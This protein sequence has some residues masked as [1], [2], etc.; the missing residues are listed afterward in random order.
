MEIQ[1][2]R[3]GEG[4]LHRLNVLDIAKGLCMISV[5]FAHVNLTPMFLIPIYSF[6][7]PL[8]FILAG[9]VYDPRKYPRL[10]DQIQRRWHTLIKP[11]LF[12]SVTAVV[13]VFVAEKL[14]VHAEDLKLREYVSA[15]IQIVIAQGSKPVLNTPL[16]FVPCLFAIEIMYFFLAKLKT[17]SCAMVCFALACVGWLLQSGMLPFDNS[18]LPWTFDSALFALSFYA[19]G[20]RMFP[21]IRR[22]I[23]QI[24]QHPKRSRICLE[25]LFVC[26][27]I[28]LPLAKINGK[29]SLGS[30]ILNNGFLFFLTGMLGTFAV[31]L[32]S[33]MLENN[34]FL[35]WMGKNTFCLMSVHYMLRRYTLPKYYRMLGIPLYKRK[36]FKETIIPFLIIFLVSILL[37]VMYNISKKMLAQYKEK[38]R[39]S[40]QKI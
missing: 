8:F 7:M 37:T 39:R 3:H 28:W 19:A 25:M 6:H 2:E 34:R 29:V 13:Y 26:M 9:M 20:N 36:V 27:L 10:R 40:E 1:K 23:E 17:A 15:F 35:L 24:Q 18:K 14:S 22:K 30:Q 5:I 21:Y 16:W 33:I 12:F 32:I 38:K 31:L 11:Y 4:N